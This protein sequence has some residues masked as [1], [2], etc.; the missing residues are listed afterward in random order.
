M[1]E[2]NI[3]VVGGSSGIGLEI[4]RRLHKDRHRLVVGSRSNDRLKGLDGV[5]H[6]PLDVESD[7]IDVDGLPD[8]LNGM[9][10]CPGSIN[11][12]PFQRLT[13]D[14]VGRPRGRAGCKRQSV[15]PAKRQQHNDHG[16]GQSHHKL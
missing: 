5:Q 4:V 11:L 2:K 14:G 16:L 1:E 8:M 15:N 6:L 3:F 13:S 12:R 10:Y 9:V 7:L